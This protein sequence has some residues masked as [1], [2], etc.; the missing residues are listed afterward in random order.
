MTP[1]R[2]QILLVSLLVLAAVGAG[3]PLGGSLVMVGFGVGSTPGLAAVQAGAAWSGRYP[4]IETV[5]RRA[6]PLLAAAVL[7]W[8]ALMVPAAHA[9]PACH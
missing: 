9:A 6:I 5:L 7:V 8:R 2:S 4:R 3:T 1:R